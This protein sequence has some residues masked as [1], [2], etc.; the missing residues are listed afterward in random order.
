MI[1]TWNVLNR[2]GIH[3]IGELIKILTE[4]RKEISIRVGKSSLSELVGKLD[5]LGLL[6]EKLMEVIDC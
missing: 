6:S 5:E 2:N 4:D 3:T 1:R